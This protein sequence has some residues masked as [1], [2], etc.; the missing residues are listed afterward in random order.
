MLEHLFRQPAEKVLFLGW[1]PP[2][3]WLPNN[4]RKLARWSESGR[5]SWWES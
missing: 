1:S 2:R 3:S 5:R 4:C